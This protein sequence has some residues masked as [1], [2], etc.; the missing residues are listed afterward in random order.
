M[1]IW[2][3]NVEPLNWF[4]VA[5]SRQWCNHDTVHINLDGNLLAG[6]SNH[7]TIKTKANEMIMDYKE[8]IMKSHLFLPLLPL[9]GGV[10]FLWIRYFNLFINGLRLGTSIFF[11]NSFF[12]YIEVPKEGKNQENRSYIFKASYILL[13]RHSYCIFECNL[14]I[15]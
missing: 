2:K 13:I 11:R 12:S 5:N 6:L 1:K 7:Q 9:R 15:L 14:D 10:A 3:I 4:H 8:N